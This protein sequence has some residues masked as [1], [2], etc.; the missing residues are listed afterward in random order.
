[1][2]AVERN[3]DRAYLTAGSLVSTSQEVI[4]SIGIYPIS[5]MFT[6]TV[7][8]AEALSNQLRETAMQARMEKEVIQVTAEVMEKFGEPA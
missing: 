6:L 7:E 3:M 1:M 5:A 2:N 4:L 8:E